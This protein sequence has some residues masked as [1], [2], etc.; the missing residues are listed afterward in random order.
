MATSLTKTETARLA[1]MER[2][3]ETGMHTFIEVGTA[4]VAIRDE[5]LYKA[6]HTTFEAYCKERWGMSR[7]HAHSFA[8]PDGFAI[9]WEYPLWSIY[10][11][12]D[13]TSL[14]K[15]GSAQ[16]DEMQRRRAALLDLLD[17]KPMTKAEWRKAAESRNL[18]AS[19][20]TWKGDM[21]ALDSKIDALGEPGVQGTKYK[22]KAKP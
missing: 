17:A 13:H 22:R 20:G 15:P 10:E 6:S 4:L 1:D 3:I 12:V 9:R 14:K 16:S 19:D 8:K 7:I 2:V 5:R 11:T 21:R 18:C